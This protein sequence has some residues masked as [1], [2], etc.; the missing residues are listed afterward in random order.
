MTIKR[1]AAFITEDVYY[2]PNKK[3]VDLEKEVEAI[4][5][6]IIDEQTG[7]ES[8]YVIVKYGGFV[9]EVGSKSEAKKGIKASIDNNRNKEIEKMMSDEWREEAQDVVDALAEA[10]FPGYEID[11]CG[12]Y[13]FSLSMDDKSKEA[14]KKRFDIV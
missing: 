12:T 6:K 8:A 10:G 4:T 2:E 14:L 13:G 9:I 7:L 11:S 1:F 3:R 5:S